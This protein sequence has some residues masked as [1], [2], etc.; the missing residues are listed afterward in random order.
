MGPIGTVVTHSQPRLLPAPRPHQP[1]GPSVFMAPG[2]VLDRWH[3]LP[4]LPESRP[5][6]RGL[7]RPHFCFCQRGGCGHAHRGL[8]RDR[9]GPAAGEAGVGPWAEGAGT[10]PRSPPPIW[11]G[12]SCLFARFARQ[13]P[14]ATLIT[15]GDHDDLIK[16]G[17][18]PE[19]PFRAMCLSLGAGC[20]RPR[21]RCFGDLLASLCFPVRGHPENEG[22]PA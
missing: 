12:P 5:R 2:S 1:A 19:V 10:P 21:S 13:K 9:A 15:T 3:L 4:H 8:C 7:H 22:H 6:A 18:F 14:S 20:P 16:E 17:L 11:A